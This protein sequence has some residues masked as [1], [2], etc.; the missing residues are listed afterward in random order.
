MDIDGSNTSTLGPKSGDAPL[1]V[2][3]HDGVTFQLGVQ[4]PLL[5]LS[6][7]ASA[8]PELLL[9]V[10]PDPE[11][12]LEL[13]PELLELPPELPPELLLELLPELLPG[14]PP[15]PLLEP[16]PESLLKVHS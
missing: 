15:E 9:E 11:L 4:G 14:P 6:L 8:P 5:P 1:V 2:P 13:L 10:L 3:P 16:V 7:P 12:L